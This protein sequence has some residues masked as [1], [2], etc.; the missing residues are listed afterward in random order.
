LNISPS[1]SDLRGILKRALNDEFP[2]IDDLPTLFSS[3]GRDIFLLS[4]VADII[5]ERQVGSTITY[6]INRNINFTNICIKKCPFC[7]YSVPKDSEKGYLRI[8][9]DYFLQ[10]IEETRPYQIT[11][12][13]IQGGIHP[14][15]GL[16]T[17]IEILR[18][19]REIDPTLHIHAFSPQEVTHAAKSSGEDIDSVLRE[20]KRHGIGSLPGTAAEILDD[21]IRKLICPNKISTLEWVHIIKTA[22]KLGIPTTST[23]LFGH[24]EK[25]QHWIRHLSLLKEIQEETHGFTEFIPLPFISE[26]TVFQRMYGDQIRKLTSLEYIKYYA[27]ARMYLGDVFKN[28]QTSWVKLGFPL[29]QVTLT[30]GCNDFGGT[31][32][33]ENITRMAG[34][35]FGQITTPEKFQKRISSLNRP[36]SERGTLYNHIR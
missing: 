31:L 16:E 27:I 1:S 24:I 2:S 20:F 3:Q 11:E 29:A 6:V 10:K 30:A 4:H 14:E 5:R 21:K 17:Y 28:I 9:R 22:H 13:C 26:N 12:V 8:S 32:F 34:G 25:D 18:N 7:A 35:K 23:I 15:I 19:I 33:E 36:F